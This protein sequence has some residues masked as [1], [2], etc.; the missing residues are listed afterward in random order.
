MVTITSHCIC[1]FLLRL[2][3]LAMTSQKANAERMEVNFKLNQI[4][5]Q[6]D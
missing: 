5:N 2:P 3:I 4:R 1:F 6:E